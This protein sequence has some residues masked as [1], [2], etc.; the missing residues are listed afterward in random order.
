MPLN[1]GA[2]FS[3][4]Y[5]SGAFFIEHLSYLLKSQDYG[6]LHWILLLLSMAPV[7]AIAAALLQGYQLFRW[8]AALTVL[9]STTR[10]AIG[11]L[12]VLVGLGIIS[13]FVGTFVQQTSPSR[14]R[15][16]FLV[17]FGNVHRPD[18]LRS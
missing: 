10:L 14:S 2:Y 13:A 6:N 17:W 8:S 15:S 5:V 3:L 1:R 18:S 11:F 12:M 16:C 7:T 4:V 9:T